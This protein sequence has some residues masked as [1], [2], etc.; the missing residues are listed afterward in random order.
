MACTGRLI[1][2]DSTFAD[3]HP[4]C[5]KVMYETS[6]QFAIPAALAKPY[7]VGRDVADLAVLYCYVAGPVGHNGGFGNKC[8]LKR[9]ISGARKQRLVMMKNQAL[10]LDMLYKFSFLGLSLEGDK[11]FN[12]RRDDMRFTH[13]FVGQWHIVE[14]AIASQEPF[15]T[16]IECSL[17]IFEVKAGIVGP[18]RIA[19]EFLADCNYHV[20]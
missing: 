3:S 5:T 20:G 10:Q 8:S 19:F 14:R 12:Y 1:T 9:I 7:T 6:L 17:E 16:H 15:A 18:A 2:A 11:L 13:I 4:A